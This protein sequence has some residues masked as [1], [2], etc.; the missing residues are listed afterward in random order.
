MLFRVS[1]FRVWD[2]FRVCGTQRRP[3][4]A[5]GAGS[6]DCKHVGHNPKP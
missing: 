6:A 4:L 3:Q 2:N 5:S 1:E